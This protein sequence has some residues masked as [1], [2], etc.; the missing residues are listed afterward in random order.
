MNDL[1]AFFFHAVSYAIDPTGQADHV[2]E[3]T[4]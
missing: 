4:L 3:E 1:V 2:T